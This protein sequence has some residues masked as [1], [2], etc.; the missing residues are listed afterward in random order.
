M[1]KS[2]LVN[3]I[4]TNGH[5]H[6]SIDEII[7]EILCGN[8]VTNI[9]TDNRTE[10]TKYK[11]SCSVYSVKPT[12]NIVSNN[13]ILEDMADN[14]LIPKEYSSIDVVEYIIQRC[15]NETE[16]ARASIEIMEYHKRDQLIILNLMIY[17]VDTMRKK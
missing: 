10:V 3:A 16:I 11:E 1:I 9:S 2:K 12:I 7:D 8:K 4:N 6:I 5:I 14:W 13:K 17:L 15:K